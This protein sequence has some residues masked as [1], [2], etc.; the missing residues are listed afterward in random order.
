MSMSKA[1]VCNDIRRYS[2]FFFT[3]SNGT[4]NNIDIGPGPKKK[5]WNYVDELFR[6]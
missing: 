4:K 1:P 5:S 3:F 6:C 2:H